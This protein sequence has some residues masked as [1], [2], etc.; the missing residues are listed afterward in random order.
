MRLAYLGR[1]E[2]TKAPDVVQSYTADRDP[3]DTLHRSLD[4]RV[5]LTRNQLSD[6]AA[7]LQHI[8]DAG[9][10]GR[11]EPQTFFTQL[12]SAFAASAR[13]PSTI[14]HIDR[15]GP[16]LGE[17][18]DDLPYKSDV[19]SITQDTWL[20]MGAIGQRTILNN[21][22]S[23]L[24]LYQDFESHPELWVHLG[25]SKDDGEAVYPVP[26]EALP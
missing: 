19:A 20:A 10:A 23:R 7:S 1:N 2:N 6:L 17:Y 5:L 9:L 18:L 8:L 13:D 15:I 16:L 22:A 21:I 12:Q 4:V 11:I 14:S 26:L 24:R 3:A 25:H